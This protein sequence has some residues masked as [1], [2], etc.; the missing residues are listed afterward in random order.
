VN[1]NTESVRIIVMVHSSN[2]N[3]SIVRNRGEIKAPLIVYC[4]IVDHTRNTICY[5]YG[6]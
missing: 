4:T 1:T 3:E 2:L 6:M 5:N